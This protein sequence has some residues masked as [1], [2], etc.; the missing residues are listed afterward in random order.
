MCD[1]F[2][3]T[4]YMS[5]VYATDNTVN[6]LTL[7]DGDRKGL[8]VCIENLLKLPKWDC[9]DHPAWSAWKIYRF[10]KN[11]K[12]SSCIGSCKLAIVVVSL[13]VV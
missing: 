7:L 6:S 3:H 12:S 2:K 5:D 9:L 10:N 13:L 8:L 1:T 11:P 4:Q